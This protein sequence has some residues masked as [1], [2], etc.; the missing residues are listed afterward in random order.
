LG[1]LFFPS[2]YPF[3]ATVTTE[4]PGTG[5]QRQQKRSSNGR[6]LPVAARSELEYLNH[7]PVQ[8][9]SQGVRKEC[10]V[11]AAGNTK[12]VEAEQ[13]DGLESP[14]QTEDVDFH[15]IESGDT[16]SALAKRYYGDA[17]RYVKIF[18][19]NRGITIDP[20]RICPGQ[21]IRIPGA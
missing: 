21:K 3:G 5:A 4:V 8:S 1:K 14:P 6:K 11:T 19:A 10:E 20:D 16:L 13:V 18:E 2:R 12:G 15:T 7:P 17:R 9:T